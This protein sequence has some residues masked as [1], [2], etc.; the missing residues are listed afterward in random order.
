M[1]VYS[2]IHSQSSFFRENIEMYR[3]HSH[4]LSIVDSRVG[5]VD[6]KILYS[7]RGGAFVLVVVSGLMSRQW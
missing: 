1:Y 4:I 3:K 6:T 7:F 2:I 5:R